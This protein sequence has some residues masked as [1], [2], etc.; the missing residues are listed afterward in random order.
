MSNKSGFNELTRVQIPALVHLTRLG[1]S[2]LSLKEINIH[3][4]TGIL[5]DIFRDQFTKFNPG[6]DFDIEFKTI[7]AELNQDDLG[8][9][10]YDRLINSEYTLI[11]FKHPNRNTWHIASEIEHEKNNEKFRPDIT[12]FINGLPLSFIEVK[13]PNAIRYGQTGIQSESKRTIYRLSKNEFRRFNNITQL[14]IFSDNMPYDSS[15]GQLQGAYYT[16]PSL[17]TAKFN[18]F[19][20]QEPSIFNIPNIEEENID[21]I[22]KDLNKQTLKRSPEFESN[23]KS[24]TP[25]NQ[26]LTSLLSK[27]RIL[28]FLQYGLVYVDEMNKD[29]GQLEIQKHIM[30]YPQ[31][32]ATKA[33]KNTIKEGI[34]K[35]VI[36]HTQGSGK[37]ALAYHTIRY[38][39]DI[40]QK[41]NIIPHFYFVVDRLDLANQTT[42]EFMKRGLSVK[43][44]SSSKELN[45]PFTQDVAIV[46]IQK[47]K[48]ETNFKNQSGYNLNTQNIYFIDE[49]HRSYNPKG[50]YLANLYNADED[51]IKIALTG[52]PLIAPK[53]FDTNGEIVENA[54]VKTT[55]KIFGDYIHKYYYNDSIAD[56]FTL[57]LIREDIE[58]QY[59]TELQAKFDEIK[60]KQGTF[61]KKMIFSHPSFVSSML[62][63][64]IEDFSNFRIAQADTSIGAMVV[65]N[66]S[67]QAKELFKK[68][69][70][71]YAESLGYSAALVLHDQEDNAEKVK[72]FKAGK[73]DFLFVYS[74][75]LTGFDAPKLKK[76]YL[77][78]RIKAHN[79][80]QTLTRVNR[81]YKNYIQG[82]V[83]DFADIS[84]DFE[85]TNQAYLEELTREY[86]TGLTGED[87]ENIFGSLF[88]S[89]EEIHE[90]LDKADLVL[91][92]YPTD[93]LEA[94]EGVI[95]DINDRK[96]LNEL[97]QSLTDIK[98]N[99]QLARLLQHK[100]ILERID[101]RLISRMLISLTNRLST[102]NLLEKADDASGEELL[103]LVMNDA[104]FK[105][106]KVGEAELDLTAN[107][108]QETRKKAAANLNDNWD[109][110]DP[111]FISLLDEFRRVMEKQNAM[112]KEDLET[113][114]TVHREYERILNQIAKLN[115]ENKQLAANYSGDKK[116]ARVAK[117]LGMKQP[118]DNVTLHYVLKNTKKELDEVVLN[119]EA[120]LDNEAF[121]KRTTNQIVFNVNKEQEKQKIGKQ[122]L[123]I[124]ILRDIST[125]ASK[126]YLEELE[127]AY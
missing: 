31:F 125:L 85:E 99:F 82:Y 126:E 79:L 116:Y 28:F 68:F 71:F 14:M 86:D 103:N 23:K 95:S 39:K 11:D 38:L 122:K 76:L 94:F 69:N 36:W 44:I 20:E 92:N 104:D 18:S 42:E 30:R 40:Y 114:Q 81:P 4:E 41:Q 73:I 77:G 123:N 102:L 56:G 70:D 34:K 100:D 98:D 75:L 57:R 15:L 5:E 62:T 67:E 112:E 47:F 117:R 12:I 110:T 48:N 16:T 61:D 13:Q 96:R 65:S 51:S 84:K 9:A 105:F 50:S 119:N 32:F 17:H 6:I 111:A 3:N 55:R 22:L 108:L 43:K 46:N 45:I 29:T 115:R 120:V 54:D 35:G 53:K 72:A 24:N 10:F 64:I 90:K 127:G 118:S 97:R 59:K 58:T 113:I 83:V 27:E 78:R 87:A 60:I 106:V 8:R 2:Y 19:K 63:Y 89:S 52:T 49:A 121:F 25:T 109:K 66:S 80:L 93:N 1:Y 33:I 124:K 88:V 107:D 91:I 7:I 26:I 37:T 74:M 101:I 21:L